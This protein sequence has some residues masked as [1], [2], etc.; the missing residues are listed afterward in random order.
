MVP[1]GDASDPTQILGS[2]TSCLA[3]RWNRQAMYDV[4]G[5]FVVFL[6]NFMIC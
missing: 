6:L 4:Y 2:V 3:A 5:W 1:L